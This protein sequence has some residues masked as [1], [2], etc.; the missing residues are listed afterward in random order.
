MGPGRPERRWAAG[1]AVAVPMLVFLGIVLAGYDGDPYLRG[2]CRYYVAAA[3]SI[4]EDGDLD[5]A[6]QLWQPWDVHNSQVAMDRRGRFV[7]KHPL[8]MSIALI[9]FLALFG[10]PGALVFNLLQMGV[11][12]W[13][14][15]LLAERVGGCRAAALAVWLTALFSFLPHY[16]WNVSP[17]VFTSAAML[18]AL[19]LLPGDRSEARGRHLLSGLLLGV[20]VAAKPTFL[21]AALP[22]PLVMGRPLRRTAPVLAIGLLLPISAW[23][24]LNEYLFGHPLSTSYDR[25]VHFTPDGIEL[26]SNREDFTLSMVDGAWAQLVHPEKGLLA[27]SP[28]TVLSIALLPLFFR[29]QRRW[30]TVVAVASAGIFLFFS[31]YAPWIWSH[32]GN[33]FLMPVV[34]LGVMPA[35]GALGRLVRPPAAP[36]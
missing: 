7:P 10:N 27:T 22:F 19:V 21:L 18:G 16:A 12:C 15:F 13:L 31:R 33:R 1:L 3:R 4:A 8:W 6:N 35:A 23:L 24:G 25:I 34:V 11:L 5:L 14:M 30:A 17:D 26:H 9:P 36:D 2:D 29:D 28:V 20:A 32:W